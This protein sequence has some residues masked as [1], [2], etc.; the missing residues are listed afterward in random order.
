MDIKE[1]INQN[2]DE[3]VVNKIGNNFEFRPHQKETIVDIIYGIINDTTKD[4]IVEAPTGSGKSLINII[5]AGVLADY[6]DKSSFI[7]CS[8]RYLFKQYEDFIIKHPKIDFGHILG[9]TDNYECEVNG[10]DLREAECQIAGLSWSKLCDFKKARDLGFECASWCYYKKMRFKAIKAK[11]T[12]MTYQLFLY[13]AN[14]TAVDSHGNPIRVFGERNILFCDEC[15]NIPEIVQNQY[16]PTIKTSDFDKLDEIYNFVSK[17]ASLFMNDDTE[18]VN[19]LSEYKTSKELDNALYAQFNKMADKNATNETLLDAMQKYLCILK[20]FESTKNDILSVIADKKIHKKPLTK[21]ELHIHKLCTWLGN[22][23]CFW[24]D[25]TNAVSAVGDKYIVREINYT[26]KNGVIVTF[27]CTKED[28]MIYNY[29][30]SNAPYKVFCSATVGDK[31]AYAENMGFR[32]DT[33]EDDSKVKMSRI[34]STFDFSKSPIYFYNHFKM[35]YIEKNKSFPILKKVIYSIC[36]KKFANQRGMIQTGSY[37]FAKEIYNDASYNI[38]QR[39]LLYNNA[40]EKN[41]R[42]SELKFYDDGILIGPT[43]N[44]GIDLPDDMC[45][46]IIILKVPYPSL[47]SNLVKAKMKLF[48][49]WYEY[50]TSNTIIQGIGRG[51]RNPKDYCTTY[52]LDACFDKLYNNTKEQYSEELQKRIIKF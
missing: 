23:M 44:E 13:T 3:W 14:M 51:I 45:R 26:P 36:E 27:N 28:Y 49:Q 35:S 19:L 50:T 16:S 47:A 46:F 42:I 38:K 4:Y 6:Y 30:L 7:L 9:Q 15:H 43:L 33:D 8:D 37:A 10:K 22:N 20:A 41:E 2:I 21:D 17:D 1:L 29:L 40:N 12:L 11:V 39:L 48:P 31:D 34:P 18:D 5:S 32:F 24:G 52:I 25:F